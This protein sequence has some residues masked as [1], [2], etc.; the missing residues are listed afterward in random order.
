MKNL[1]QTGIDIFYETVF[2]KSKHLLTSTM[3]KFIEMEREDKEI[4]RELLKKVL[5]CYVE[6]GKT[7]ASV[8]K[9][10][11]EGGTTKF[12]VHGKDNLEN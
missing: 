4:D 9:I 5:A 7:N 10:V 6:M 1:Y 12:V 8:Q 11:E 2:D 3:V